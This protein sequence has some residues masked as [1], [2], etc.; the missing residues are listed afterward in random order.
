[1]IKTFLALV[2]LCV[3]FFSTL[4]ARAEI[5]NIDN[6]ELARLAASGVPVIDIRTE[7]EWKETGVI[8]GSRLLTFFD[9]NGRS[10]PPQWLEKIKPIAKPEQPVILV[11][12]SGNRTR[13]AAQFLSEQA[14]YK[15]VYNVSQGIKA[16]A[17]DAR[18]LV[19]PSTSMAVC[20]A[21][22][23]C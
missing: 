22:T 20:A 10:N 4:V 17:G 13:A 12:R 7:G 9:E 15:T 18:P 19:P 1:M 21:G 16:W 14:G 3:L 23:R 5:I 11:C 6:A 8:A 2:V